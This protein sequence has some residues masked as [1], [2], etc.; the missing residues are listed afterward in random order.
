MTY[1]QGYF[2]LL[3]SAS[4]DSNPSSPASVGRK[5][6][7]TTT[8]G[9]RKQSYP[10]KAPASPDVVTTYQQ[11]HSNE[12]QA[13]DFT[14][15]SSKMKGKVILV[16]LVMFLLV[17]KNVIH[18]HITLLIDFTSDGRSEATIRSTK[19]QRSEES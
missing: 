13:Y 10:S 5:E 14:T 11:E 12:E 16:L 17:C 8:K 15:W 19:W 9:R 1:M 2:L 3:Q 6:T 4:V 18:C 7:A